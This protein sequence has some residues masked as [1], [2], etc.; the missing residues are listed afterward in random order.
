MADGGFPESGASPTAGLPRA[1]PEP[2]PPAQARPPLWRRM[3]RLPLRLR[4][5]LG[6]PE[7]FGVLAY[8][9]S[10]IDARLDGVEQ[11][12]AAM[13]GEI[14]AMHAQL[15]RLAEQQ[16]VFHAAARP[17]PSRG[18]PDAGT[19]GIAE[20]KREFAAQ[21]AFSLHDMARTLL[22]DP[23]RSWPEA[24]EG[25]PRAELDQVRTEFA[26]LADAHYD[27]KSRLIDHSATVAANLEE[28]KA[29][30]GQTRDLANHLNDSLHT[31]LNTIE[32]LRLSGLYLQMH[33]V[34]AALLRLRAD[35]EAARERDQEPHAMAEAA[36]PAPRDLLGDHLRRARQDFPRLFPLW[37]ERLQATKDAFVATKVGNAA[38]AGDPRSE[39]FRSVVE[40]YA[41]G[42]VLDVCCG[43]FGR[44]HYLSRYP[45]ELIA[46]LDP[47][48]P[49]ETPDFEFVR[50][51]QE[52]LPWSDGAFATVISATSLDHCLSLDRSLA[53]IRRVLAPDG[54]F[55]LWIDSVPGAPLFTP[56]AADFVPADRYHLFHFDTAW[57]EPMLDRW[58]EIADRV[59]LFGLGF[60]RV[61]YCLQARATA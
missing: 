61:M 48:A 36:C 15:H 34:L 1:E 55:L 10:H 20:L 6:V 39:V 4:A 19:G 22:E 23:A 16:A 54:R 11:I 7:Q 14:A 59:E 50:G 42:R 56:E 2:R 18:E 44:P 53:E 51:M 21:L 60:N 31:R 45:A 24:R 32:N 17:V 5:L 41:R 27:T 29:L 9:T 49:V 43:V 37:E 12:A 57:F 33:D 28:L 8:R 46:G 13:R 25:L 58:F 35:L 47:L 30:S 26:R 40:I 52:Y 3:A 38:H